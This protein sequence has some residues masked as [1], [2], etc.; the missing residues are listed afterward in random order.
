MGPVHQAG[1]IGGKALYTHVWVRQTNHG[2]VPGSDLL[3]W[4]V[5]LLQTKHL[6]MSA[7][8]HKASP[9]NEQHCCRTQVFSLQLQVWRNAVE[10]PLGHHVK[11]VKKFSRLPQAQ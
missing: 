10:S 11:L 1:G 9:L 6:V 7:V 8:R 3:S 5:A 4:V 2:A